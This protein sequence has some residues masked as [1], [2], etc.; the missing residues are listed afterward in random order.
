MLLRVVTGGQESSFG[1]ELKLKTRNN[2][3][4]K[5]C[6]ESFLKMLWT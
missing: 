4:L 1:G 5:I 3:S 6:C 2:L